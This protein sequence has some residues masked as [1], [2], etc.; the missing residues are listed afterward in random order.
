MCALAMQVHAWTWSTLTDFNQRP[1]I[2][3][4]KARLGGM[5]RRLGDADAVSA[6]ESKCRG[7]KRL[8]G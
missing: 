5:L 7:E 3:V 4:A 2:H 8:S 6:A 1:H